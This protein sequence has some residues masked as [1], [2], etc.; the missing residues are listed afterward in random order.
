MCKEKVI[1]VKEPSIINSISSSEQS[2]DDIQD[3]K[4]DLSKVDKVKSINEDLSFDKKV[5]RS[6]INDNSGLQQLRENHLKNT[7][8]LQ[9]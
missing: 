5:R 7:N 3:A 2:S 1:E 9:N 8:V 4:E 6:S